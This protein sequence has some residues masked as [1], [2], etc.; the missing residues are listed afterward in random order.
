MTVDEAKDKW[1]PMSAP[2]GHNIGC[3]GPKCMAWR[4]HEYK[5]FESDPDEGSCG[6]VPRP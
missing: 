2:I 4:W 6:L 1:C 3:K 5:V